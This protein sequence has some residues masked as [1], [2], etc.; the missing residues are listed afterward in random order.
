M[1]F[2]LL[3]VA[4]LNAVVVCLFRGVISLA[5]VVLL[6]GRT[7]T[8][9]A[10]TLQG[11]PTYQPTGLQTLIQVQPHSAL[12]RVRYESHMPGPVELE[13]RN[14]QRCV[15]Y[16]ER[17]RQAQFVGNYDLAHLPAGDYTLHVSAAGFHHV[18]V[19]RLQRATTAL[20]TVELIKPDDF[21][22]SPLS[23]FPSAATK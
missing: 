13:L 1:L 15:V 7:P 23:L 14:D 9:S 19:L 8:I 22:V 2:P 10:Q 6:L 16:S 21:H 4:V 12:V 17:K 5:V 20:V 3:I 18:E 11:P